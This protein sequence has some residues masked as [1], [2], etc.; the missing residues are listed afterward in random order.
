MNLSRLLKKSWIL[1]LLKTDLNQR[2][3][4]ILFIVTLAY[5]YFSK[6]V[7]RPLFELIT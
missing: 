7:D 2:F 6:N 4:Y 1:N 3:Y 5:Y